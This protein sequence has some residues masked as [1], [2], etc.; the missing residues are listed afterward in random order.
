MIELLILGLGSPFGDD[1]LGWEVVRLLQQREELKSY[2]SQQV[3]MVC[4]DR[5]GVH[6]LELMSNA[7][8]VFL[9]DAV[10]TGAKLGSLHCF[11]PEEI[12]V[13]STLQS[14]HDFGI[15]QT[16]ALGKALNSLPQNLFLYGI[17]INDVKFQFEISDPINQATQALVEQILK[18]IFTHF[19]EK[20]LSI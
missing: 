2:S 13:L 5:P 7:K 8:T 16:L 14:T 9:I 18:S 4:G 3:Q 17:E 10:K 11:N 6:L 20:G 15:A 19:K 12:K 1:R